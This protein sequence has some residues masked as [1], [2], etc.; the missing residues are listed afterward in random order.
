MLNSG[1]RLS[2]PMSQVAGEKLTIIIVK[3]IKTR[4][5][6]SQGCLKRGSEIIYYDFTLILEGI[7]RL[8]VLK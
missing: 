4:R 1:M 6:W 7:R 2:Q 3:S 5:I 8:T